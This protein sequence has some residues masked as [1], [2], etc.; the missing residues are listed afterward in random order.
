MALP[1]TLA[2]TLALSLTLA[3]PLPLTLALALAL[4]LTLA[5]LLPAA[6][7]RRSLFAVRRSIPQRLHLPH[8]VPR[9]FERPFLTAPLGFAHG[10]RRGG[11]LLAHRA[12]LLADL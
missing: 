11:D 8:Q 9:P 4:A 2:L 6:A 7:V 3:L 10:V 5:G 12:D 1:L